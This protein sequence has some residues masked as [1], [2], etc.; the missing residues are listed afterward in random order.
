MFVLINLVW[1]ILV[2]MKCRFTSVSWWEYHLYK[3][4]SDIQ[5]Y[6]VTPLFINVCLNLKGSLWY[7]APGFEHTHTHTLNLI[8]TFIHSHTHTLFFSLTHT[9][10]HIHILQYFCHFC[11][12]YFLIGLL[13]NRIII[14]GPFPLENDRFSDLH[15]SPPSLIIHY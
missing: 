5:K 15:F 3:Y 14:F 1:M 7:W 4:R 2:F 9:N 12:F 13:F 11:V 6:S 10:K 8:H